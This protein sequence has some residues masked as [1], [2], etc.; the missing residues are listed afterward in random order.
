MIRTWGRISSSCSLFSPLSNRLP[1]VQRSARRKKALCR[2]EQVVESDYPAP[3]CFQKP[4]GGYGCLRFQL[5]RIS[6]RGRFTM[7]WCIS[8]S[9]RFTEMM[10]LFQCITAYEQA[11]TCVRII[12][13]NTGMFVYKQLVKPRSKI[14]GYLSHTSKRNRFQSSRAGEHPIS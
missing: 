8:Y 9:V 14:T 13:L 10:T 3:S 6:S 5:C 12:N 4:E 11:L 1:V 2:I 7:K